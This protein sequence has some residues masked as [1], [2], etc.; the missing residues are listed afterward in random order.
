[1]KRQRVTLDPIARRPGR[2]ADAEAIHALIADNLDEGHLLPRHRDELALHASRFTVAIHRGRVIGCAELVPLSPTRAELRSLAVDA[3]FRG[4]G[5]GANLVAD[6]Q[7]RAQAAGFDELCLMTHTPSYFGQLGFSVVPHRAIPEKVATD[8][9]QCPKFGS[10]G[11]LAMVLPLEAAV[12]RSAR[13]V[14]TSIHG[15]RRPI[16]IPVHAA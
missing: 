10:C 2:S 11:Q 5:I 3:T 16:L 14:D 13:A 8:C 7:Q 9:V 15:A 1:M 12:E 6:V 4:R